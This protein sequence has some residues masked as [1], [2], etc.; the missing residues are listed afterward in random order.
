MGVLVYWRRGGRKRE[1][2][3]RIEIEF[4]MSKSEREASGID[5]KYVMSLVQSS[6]REGIVKCVEA[7]TQD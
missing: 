6:L 4:N 5:L 3:Y 2:F 1:R 7:R